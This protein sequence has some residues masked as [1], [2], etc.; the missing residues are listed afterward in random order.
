MKDHLVR[1]MYLLDRMLG[2]YIQLTEVRGNLKVMSSMFGS[3]YLL[4]G[5]HPAIRS[6]RIGCSEAVSNIRLYLLQKS[7][8]Y[9]SQI[10]N[11]IRVSV[12]RKY[13]FFEA[14]SLGVEAPRRCGNCLKCKECSFRGQ[15]L[16]QQEQYEYHVIESKVRYDQALRCLRVEY[17]FM[18]DPMVLSKNIG[19]V[20]KIA[21]REEKKLERDGLIECFN[22]EFDKMI[23]QGAL[24]ELSNED[25]Q[26][27]K[28]ALHYVSLQHV[29]K[30]ES[31]TTPLRIVINS[32][33]SDK[34]GVSLSSILMEGP[35]M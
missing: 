30:S 23:N 5:V 32:S 27:W 26:F 21:E 15:Q 34:R 10:D 11:K 22:H 16:S 3:G 24:V 35:N 31:S 14:E 20:T 6:T 8:L 13:D 29:I 2:I 4:A 25:M 17:P 19:Q 9:P 7:K 28:G 1:S 33:L 12:K 18:E